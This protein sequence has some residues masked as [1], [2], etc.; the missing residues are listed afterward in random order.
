MIFLI[1]GI[2]E[3][4]KINVT[5]LSL[6]NRKCKIIYVASF[7]DSL[8]NSLRCHDISELHT[9][10]HEDQR[11]QVWLSFCSE[12]PTPPQNIYINIAFV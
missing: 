9:S 1:C 10:F 12:Y 2:N 4:I 7:C 6:T 11:K 3:I 5:Y 8:Y